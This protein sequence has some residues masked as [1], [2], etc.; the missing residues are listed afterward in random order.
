MK[1][2]VVEFVVAASV[3]H[4][5][6]M[7]TGRTALWWPRSHAV[8]GAD[9]ADIT[10]EQREGGRIFERDGDGSEHEWGAVTAWEPPR[11]IAYLWHLF[12]DPSEATRVEVTFIASGAG[13]RVRIE[14]TG[15]ERLGSAGR[16]RRERTDASW[17]VVADALAAAV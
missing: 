2:L 14:Q 11:R 6:E 9:L 4:A 10:F 3:D 12:F 16:T 5:F 1:P 15:F 13:T 8:S 7:W 17:R